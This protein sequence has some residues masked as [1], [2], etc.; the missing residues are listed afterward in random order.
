MKKILIII[1]FV[2]LSINLYSKN[3]DIEPIIM[4]AYS[5]MQVMNLIYIDVF[6]CTEIGI[7]KYG[8]REKNKIAK[9]FTDRKAYSELFFTSFVLN[10]GVYYFLN[11]LSNKNKYCSVIFN[12]LKKA[13]VLILGSSEIKAI[14]SWFDENI[15]IDIDFRIYYIFKF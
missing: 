10:S 13:Y 1:V 4:D 5:F 12:V 14:Q 7:E 3:R 8:F 9:C 11:Y 15:N 6:D 2:F